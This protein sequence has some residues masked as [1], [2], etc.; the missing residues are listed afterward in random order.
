MYLTFASIL[1][2]NSLDFNAFQKAHIA[3]KLGPEAA[4]IRKAYETFDTEKKGYIELIE[5][6]SVLSDTA[7]KTLTELIK[8]VDKNTDGR[9]T[10]ATFLNALTAD[11]LKLSANYAQGRLRGF[12]TLSTRNTHLSAHSIHSVRSSR[13]MTRSASRLSALQTPGSPINDVI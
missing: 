2:K 12:M 11:N 5:I 6:K 4:A 7:A 8:Q 9:V 1:Q 13:S 3:G 10:F